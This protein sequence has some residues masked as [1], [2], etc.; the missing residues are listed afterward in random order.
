MTPNTLYLVLVI[1][2]AALLASLGGIIALAVEGI[3]SP[4]V[5]VA[6][7]PTIIA[8][9]LGLLIPRPVDDGAGEHR[10]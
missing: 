5:L 3:E 10:G 1:L 8:G 4:Q 2:G 7:P 6:T 9:M